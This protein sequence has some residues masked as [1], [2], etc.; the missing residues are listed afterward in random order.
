ML[1][2][3]RKNHIPDLP[4]YQERFYFRPGNLGFPVFRTRYATIGVQTCWDNF[5]PEGARALGLKGAEI[6]FCPTACSTLSG[7]PKWERAIVGHAVYNSLYA[8]RVNRVGTEGSM[9]FYGKSFC[10]DPNGGFVAE[11]AGAEEGA[12]LADVDLDRIKLVRDDWTFVRERRPEIYRDLVEQAGGRKQQAGCWRG[13][14][15]RGRRSCGVPVL[16][17]PPRGKRSAVRR[18]MRQQTASVAER[19]VPFAA[20][21]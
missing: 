5:F 8:V 15:R 14:R 18:S 3:Y 11:P 12:I 10:V 13:E 20:I 16:Y 19:A 6:L 2:V 1:G 21:R 9:S 17:S 4:N 7:A